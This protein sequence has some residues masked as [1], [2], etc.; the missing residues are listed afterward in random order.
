MVKEAWEFLHNEGHINQG[1]LQGAPPVEKTSK[2]PYIQLSNWD[3]TELNA[4]LAFAAPESNSCKL[5]PF[6]NT[7]ALL[8]CCSS[9]QH[10]SVSK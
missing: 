4:A 3:C 7:A 2:Q 5:D 8:W 10:Q 1:I 6:A 9:Q